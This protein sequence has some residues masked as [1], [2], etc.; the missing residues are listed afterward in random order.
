MEQRK[1]IILDRIADAASGWIGSTASIIIHSLFFVGIFTLRLLH[2]TTEA[3]LLILTAIVS[4]EAIYLS[5][6]IQRSVNKQSEVIEEV[7][8]ALDEAEADHEGIAEETVQKLEKPLDE[9]VAEIREDVK[10]LL[11]EYRG[12]NGRPQA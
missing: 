4:L 11:D 3:I 2:I 8:E 9:I 5:I 10:E 7:E 1:P 6:F 12:K